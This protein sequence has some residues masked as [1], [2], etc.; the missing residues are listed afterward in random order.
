MTTAE[1]ARRVKQL[2][3]RVGYRE[4]VFVTSVS[5]TVGRPMDPNVNVVGEEEPFGTPQEQD[6][7]RTKQRG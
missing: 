7:Q 3:E 5:S 4:V 1:I 2:E 6:Q